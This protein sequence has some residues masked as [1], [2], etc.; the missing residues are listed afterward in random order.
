M[1]KFNAQNVKLNQMRGFNALQAANN[2]GLGIATPPPMPGASAVPSMPGQSKSAPQPAADALEARY[3]IILTNA[4]ALA[5]K[6][7]YSES[8]VRQ[9]LREAKDEI[10]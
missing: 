1:P 8:R 4:N 3:G 10:V 5:R 2:M 9:I 6:Y 7:G